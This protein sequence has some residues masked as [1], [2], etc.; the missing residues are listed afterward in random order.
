MSDFIFGLFHFC[1]A[2]DIQPIASQVIEIAKRSSSTDNISVIAVFFKDPKQIIT[3]Y[4]SR[5]SNQLTTMDF[6]SANGLHH[7][8]EHVAM[9]TNNT[10]CTTTKVVDAL[11]MESNDFYF[12]KN[13]GTDDDFHPN[14]NTESSHR[15]N[16]DGDKFSSND[17]IH[18]EHDDFGPETD[19]DA[20]DDNAISPMTPT[21]SIA[22]FFYFAADCRH[23]FT[24]QFFLTPPPQN[25]KKKKRSTATILLSMLMKMLLSTT[26]IIK[27]ISVK[28]LLKK[29]MMI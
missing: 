24:I 9:P 10:D 19:V 2:G 11:T 13:G 17:A 21:V 7:L 27:W 6:E 26:T 12:G 4:K 28:R 18:D 25:K 1:F 15:S 8:D 14:I 5:N 22:R 20:M 16:G 3:E 29:P 23:E